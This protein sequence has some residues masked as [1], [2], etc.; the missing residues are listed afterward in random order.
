MKK[1][2]SNEMQYAKKKQSLVGISPQTLLEAE[3][4]M[5][6]EL[7]F[8]VGGSLY[9]PPSIQEGTLFDIKI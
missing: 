7:I 6:G 1:Q 3:K 2:E 9:I 8:P 4:I 5:H